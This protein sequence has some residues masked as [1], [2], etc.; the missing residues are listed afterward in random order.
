MPCLETMF[1]N[2][3]P[4]EVVALEGLVVFSN[5]LASDPPHLSHI[6]GS[7]TTGHRI[8]HVPLNE[9]ANI[10]KHLKG[11]PEQSLHRLC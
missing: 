5:T 8:H 1:G 2:G 11:K 3:R 10:L 4:V 9:L 6:F 7:A